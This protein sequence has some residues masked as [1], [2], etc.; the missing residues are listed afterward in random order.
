MKKRKAAIWTVYALVALVL[1]IALLQAG[2]WGATPEA[3]PSDRSQVTPRLDVMTWR[4]PFELPI[5][6]ATGFASI[7]LN[8]RAEA[9]A[10]AELLRVVPAGTGF[11]IVREEGAYWY[12]E[13][14]DFSGFVANRYCMINLPDVLPSIVYDDTNARASIIRASGKS[15]PGVTGEKLYDSYDYNPRLEREEFI[16]PLLYD[17]AKKIDAVQKA[18]LSDGNTL[19]IYEAYRPYS[20]QRKVVDALDRLSGEDDEVMAGI[21]SPPWSKTWFAAHGISYHQRGCAID[22]SLA[23]VVTTRKLTCYPYECLVVGEYVEHDMP[24]AMHELS[25][26]AAAFKSPVP[27]SSDAAWREAAPSLT[28]TDAALTLQRYCADAGLTPLASEWWHFNDLDAYA[29]VKNNPGEGASV[30]TRV[31]SRVP[32]AISQTTAPNR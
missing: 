7:E 21:N 16:M 23:R 30:L 2:A 1:A 13:G 18:A 22:A 31:Y 25:I 15:V 12:V 3:P 17:M 27:S 9:S 26:A 29:R 10:D 11:Q 28:M 19:V 32:G 5:K 6:G 8:L 4:G 14:S 24:T 20:A